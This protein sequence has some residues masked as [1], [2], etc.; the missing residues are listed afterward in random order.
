MCLADILCL[1]CHMLCDFA[2]R[3][4]FGM[5]RYHTKSYQKN[6]KEWFLLVKCAVYNNQLRSETHL[7][8]L[9]D[10]EF[11]CCDAYR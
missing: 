5:I 11:I 4:C 3:Y 8:P 2:Y 7:V 9:F 6:S 10:L 1:K